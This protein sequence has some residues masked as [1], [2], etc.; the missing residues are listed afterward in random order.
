VP[1]RPFLPDNHS[2]DSENI[3]NRSAAFETALPKLG[4]VDRSDPATMAVA[5]PTIEFAKASQRE[6]Q[7][8]CAL[9]LQSYQTVREV[10]LVDGTKPNEEL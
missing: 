2:F 4:L 8:L 7:W 10:S 6:P 5:K 3:A 9:P 1:I